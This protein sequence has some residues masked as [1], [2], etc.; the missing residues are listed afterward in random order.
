MPTHFKIENQCSGEDR[1]PVSARSGKSGLGLVEVII[2]LFIFASTIAGMC[3]VMVM[4]RTAG[5][6]ARDHYVAI[7]LA[8]N[9]LERA[10]SFGFDQLSLFAESQ[11]MLNGQG[12]PAAAGDFRRTT[13]VT[14]ITPTLKEVRVTVEIRNRDTWTF[15]PGMQDVRSYVADI[16][17]PEGQ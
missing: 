4:M 13:T 8:K 5:D 10:M 6:R 11:V 2:S 16:Q 7:N 15:V 1:A 17:T 14:T 12:A 9:R 3:A